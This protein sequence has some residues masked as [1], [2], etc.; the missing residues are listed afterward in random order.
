MAV[1][2][3]PFLN[4]DFTKFDFASFMDPSKLAEQWEKFDFAKVADQFKVP[5][6]DAQALV[7]YQKRNLE[8]VASANKIALEGAQAVIRRQAEIVRK[9]VE[10]ASKAFS[11][12]NAAETPQE[13][14]VKQAELTKQAYEAALA[15]LQELAEIASKSNGEAAS[16]LSARVSESF[17]EFTTEVKKTAKKK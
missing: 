1:S 4:G 8:A 12:L 2:N 16:L 5:G 3:T 7:E 9:S 10:D 13:K 15:N 6:L 11:E 17:G 14:L